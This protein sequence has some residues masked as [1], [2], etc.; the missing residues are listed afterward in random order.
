M[1]WELIALLAATAAV[2]FFIIV[3]GGLARLLY[4]FAI[5]AL[6]RYNLLERILEQPGAR[7]IPGSTGEAIN[8]FRDDAQTVVDM[9]GWIHVLIAQIALSTVAFILLL[10]INVQITLLVF[11]PLVCILLITQRLRTR[12][13]KYRQASRQATGR[14]S[15]IIGE[16]FSA[17]QAIQVAGAE[18]HVIAHFR[19]LNEHRRSQMLR[20][21][22]LT[23]ALDSSYANIV[24]L[25]TGFILILAALSVHTAHLGI[26]DLALFIYY[27][28]F[29][30]NY[31]QYLGTILAHYTQTKVSFKRMVT[32]LQGA[33]EKALVAHK[34]LYFRCS[35]RNH[36]SNEN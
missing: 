3:G 6:L 16:I 29:I 32:L 19:T 22:V 28:G 9:F 15:S 10:H 13:T 20:D 36:S 8:C 30:A 1:I 7:A 18:P 26:G 33:S 27:L 2:R 5:N 31:A 11:V 24:G 12:L 25:G 14:I 17:V 4:A 21:R 23:D 35:T 34:P